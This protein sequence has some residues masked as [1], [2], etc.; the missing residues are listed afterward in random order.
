MNFAGYP[1]L[2]IIDFTIR[3]IAYKSNTPKEL[4]CLVWSNDCIHSA[5]FQIGVHICMALY[6]KVRIDNKQVQAS[7]LLYYTRFN[8]SA[9][10]VSKCRP[11]AN[12]NRKCVR[13]FYIEKSVYTLT[14]INPYELMSICNAKV[15]C[16]RSDTHPSEPG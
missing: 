2:F 9:F 14:R 12:D 1:A 3:Q 13:V 7:I 15:K 5:H 10:C 6:A 8:S 11:K 4:V 16:I